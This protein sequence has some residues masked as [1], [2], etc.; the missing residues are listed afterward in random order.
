MNELLYSL[1]RLNLHQRRYLKKYISLKGDAEKTA[2]RLKIPF[3]T[4]RYWLENEPAYKKV[5]E[6]LKELIEAKL[7]RQIQR[8]SVAATIA[9]LAAFCKHRGYH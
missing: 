2:W 5:H 8:G 4:V 9:Y 3:S 1:E 7:L 6:H